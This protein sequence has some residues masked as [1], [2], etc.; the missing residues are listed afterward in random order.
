[1]DDHYGNVYI[2]FSTPFSLQK[3]IS[4][5]NVRGDKYESHNTIST[6]A[7]EIIYR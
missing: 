6:I 1:M 2:N 7:H 3:Y 5:I 4:D